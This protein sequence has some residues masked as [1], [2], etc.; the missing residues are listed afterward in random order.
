MELPSVSVALNAH[1]LFI[2]F[3]SKDLVVNATYSG[4]PNPILA[5]MCYMIQDKPL[6]ELMKFSWQTWKDY[7]KDDQNFWDYIL[8]E[9][10]FFFHKAVELLRAS[11]DVFRGREYLYKESSQ[12]VCRC[13]GVRED[14]ILN[15]LKFE[16]DATLDS[17]ITATKAGMGCRSCVP[18]LK[19]WISHYE[20]KQSKHF[21]KDKPMAHWLLLIDEALKEFPH[22]D[23]W[24][25][26]VDSIKGSQVVVSYFREASQSEEEKMNLELQS[27]L[28]DRVDTDFA[29]FLKRDRHFSNAKG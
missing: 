27:Y 18:Q 3:D 2:R 20:L 1:T 19:K 10:E 5:S 23:S 4:K 15:H 24:H 8:E 28:R 13:F 22:K 17:L 7:F 6:H 9:E 29:F 16:K 11:L 12:L 25:M 26:E 21:Y 14:D